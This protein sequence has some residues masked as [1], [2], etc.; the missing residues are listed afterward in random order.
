MD[1]KEASR[2]HAADAAPGAREP[3]PQSGL[4]PAGFAPI[5]QEAAAT[6]PK[7]ADGRNKTMGEMTPEEKREQMR[8]SAQRLAIGIRE[9]R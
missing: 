7:H 2:A 4:G 1:S 3:S 5:A 9:G 6:W 8:L